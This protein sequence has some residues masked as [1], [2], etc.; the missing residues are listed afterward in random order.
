MCVY[1]TL[2]NI[3]VAIFNPHWKFNSFNSLNDDEYAV[4]LSVMYVSTCDSAAVHVDACVSTI[5]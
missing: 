3:S 1:L 5:Y 2:I 4:C